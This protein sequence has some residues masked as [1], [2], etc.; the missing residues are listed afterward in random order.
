MILGF[1]EYANKNNIDIP[2]AYIGDYRDS[3]YREDDSDYFIVEY[4]VEFPNEDVKGYIGFS[5]EAGDYGGGRAFRFY[6][7]GKLDKE[8][9]VEYLVDLED[10]E[11]WFEENPMDFGVEW[12]ICAAYEY[13]DRKDKFIIVLNKKYNDG[14]FSC[15][16]APHYRPDKYYVLYYPHFEALGHNS[17]ENIK[18]LDKFADYLNNLNSE[19]PFILK[20]LEVCKESKNWEIK[21]QKR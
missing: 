1:Y 14:A 12:F 18:F 8:I 20:L 3:I 15:P 13:F 5:V 10:D 11:V 16:I 21:N 7:D 17:E 9:S 2:N 4:I 6:R 19:E